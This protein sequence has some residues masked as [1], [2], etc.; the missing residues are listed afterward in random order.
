MAGNE[1]LPRL[2]GLG[3]LTAAGDAAEGRLTV[4]ASLLVRM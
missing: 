1:G 2:M 3:I 4:R